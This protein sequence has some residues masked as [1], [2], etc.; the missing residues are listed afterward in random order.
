MA[1]TAAQ[2]AAATRRLNNA[3]NELLA[4]IVSEVTDTLA[5]EDDDQDRPRRNTNKLIQIPQG[6]DIAKFR[7]GLRKLVTLRKNV[8]LRR[9]LAGTNGTIKFWGDLHRTNFARALWNMINT[10]SRDEDDGASVIL[11]IFRKAMGM[12]DSASSSAVRDALIRTVNEADTVETPEPSSMEETDEKGGEL[13]QRIEAALAASEAEARAVLAGIPSAT[14][15]RFQE[16]AGGVPVNANDIPELDPVESNMPQPAPKA[17]THTHVVDPDTGGGGTGAG[18]SVENQ[19]GAS[20]TS[21]IPG[22]AEAKQSL[23][24]PAAV[25]AKYAEG[26]DYGVRDGRRQQ[27]RDW[28]RLARI[29]DVIGTQS[30]SPIDP[31]TPPTMLRAKAAVAETRLSAEDTHNRMTIVD[32]IND[33]GEAFIETLEELV[34][35]QLLG[36]MTR[37]TRSIMATM[38]ESAATNPEPWMLDVDVGAILS[39]ILFASSTAL[40][41]GNKGIDPKVAI[42]AFGF[43]AISEYLMSGAGG[44]MGRGPSIPDEKDDDFDE[45]DEGL[46]PDKPGRA[47]PDAGADAPPGRAG[48]PPGM[49]D[50]VGANL[51]NLD[52]RNLSQMNRLSGAI[53][54]AAAAMPAINTY[55]TKQFG[56][57]WIK[58]ANAIR[59]VSNWLRKQQGGKQDTKQQPQQEF[60]EENIDLTPEQR[61]SVQSGSR[62]NVRVHQD[63]TRDRRAQDLRPSFIQLGTN[64][65]TETPEEA[66]AERLKF[67]SFNYVPPGHG[68]ASDNVIAQANRIWDTQIRYTEPI[69]T[70]NYTRYTPQ[71]FAGTFRP[72]A[73]MSANPTYTNPMSLHMLKRSMTAEGAPHNMLLRDIHNN[74]AHFQPTAGL[75]RMNPSIPLSNIR[76]TTVDYDGYYLTD[77]VSNPPEGT[78]RRSVRMQGIRP[79][80]YQ[81]YPSGFS[82]NLPAYQFGTYYDNAYPQGGVPQYKQE[83]APGSNS[84][85]YAPMISKMPAGLDISALSLLPRVPFQYGDPRLSKTSPATDLMFP[86]SV[87]TDRA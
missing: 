29:A 33:D 42:A 80:P 53:G 87:Y 28:V 31:R 38:A 34:P 45:K 47:P 20:L 58:K 59:K 67:A 44:S 32:H 40:M 50:R 75:N 62:G 21:A 71:T 83:R 23:G 12:P 74:N 4:V 60:E 85:P 6:S 82:T 52:P 26:V 63:G 54:V 64:A 73:G 81:Q 25:E 16:S 46:E 72:S 68:A 48:V 56:H 11:G 14:E 7:K 1:P 2:K 70:A 51:R 15:A 86:Q 37:G 55:F 84:Q 35:P 39:S 43:D 19:F 69:Q 57:D 49:W 78:A 66:I 41:M 36:V 79:G 61:A 8:N 5:T 9:R 65:D 3:L 17:Q 76:P 27:P 77:Q 13:D 18:T 10:S 22:S 30:R 24:A